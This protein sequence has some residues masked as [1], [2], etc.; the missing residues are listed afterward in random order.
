MASIVPILTIAIP[1]YNREFF[2]DRCLKY[3]HLQI[4]DLPIEIIVSDNAST[5]NTAEIVNKYIIDGLPIRYIKNEKNLGADLNIIQCYKEAKGKYVVAFGD[6][7]FFLDQS[8]SKLINVLSNGEYG[9]VYVNNENY[10]QN[11]NTSFGNE[12][13]YV[14]FK[15]GLGFLKKVNYYTT[16]ISGN[17]VNKTFLDIENLMMNVNS[18][19]VQLS[20]I[21]RAIF[22]ANENVYI[23]SRL[24]ASEPDNSGGY[25]LFKT[26]GENLN[27][28]IDKLNIP[29]DNLITDIKGIINKNLLKNFFPIHIIRFKKT[30]N[31]MFLNTAPEEEMTVIYK[32][33]T[34]YWILCYPLFK[35]SSKTGSVYYKIVRKIYYFI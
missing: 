32:N 24:I 2:L 11:F 28:V 3:I 13:D 19:V 34:M 22:M 18:Y 33:Y 30:H 8:L 12:L 27:G 10:Y 29:N 6:D 20:F 15:D 23:N 35:L 31:E 14:I 9:V 5:D 7:D 26:F 17:I 21:L 16:F 4:K 1:T 25:N